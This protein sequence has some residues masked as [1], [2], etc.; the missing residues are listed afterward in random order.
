MFII[1]TMPRCVT[2]VTWAI[3]RQ[4]TGGR[5]LMLLTTWPSLR[6]NDYDNDIMNNDDDDDDNCTIVHT[7]NVHCTMAIASLLYQHPSFC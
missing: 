6:N 7:Y 3:S 2:L 5:G 4:S 1:I